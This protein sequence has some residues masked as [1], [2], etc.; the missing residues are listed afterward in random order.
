MNVLFQKKIAG[1]ALVAMLAGGGLTGCQWMDEHR[2]A[3]G[4]TA[5]AVV[6]GVAGRAIGGD[7]KGALIGAA[8]GAAIGGGVGYV[9]QRQKDA[10]DRIDDVEAQQTTI[11]LPPQAGAPAQQAQALQVTV[12]SDVLFEQ[13]SSA[14]S[15][16]GVQKLRE[17]AQVLNQD[18]NSKIVVMGYTSS[19]GADQMN[20]ELS[21]RRAN[22]VMNQLIAY[23]VAPARLQAVGMGESDP[24]ATN[25]TEAGR[26]QNRRVEIIV[27]PQEGSTPP[28]GYQ[29]QAPPPGNYPPPPPQY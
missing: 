6:G 14:L 4:A 13:G 2:T 16:R 24:V 9:L 29:Q 27:V 22:V 8:A 26:V 17:V 7:T 23:G 28:Q 11:N 3:T 12:G 20:L 10:F 15:A 19:E 25:D 18:P 1:M 21:Q 5:G